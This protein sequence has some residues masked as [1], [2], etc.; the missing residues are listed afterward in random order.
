MIPGVFFFNTNVWLFAY[1]AEQGFISYWYGKVSCIPFV[2]KERSCL[3]LKIWFFS[4]P[5]FFLAFFHSTC[6]INTSKARNI[7]HCQTRNTVLLLRAYRLPT[8]DRT[9]SRF[10]APVELQKLKLSHVTNEAHTFFTGLINCSIQ[11][12]SI[13]F[14]RVE[15]EQKSEDGEICFKAW[16]QFLNF[17]MHSL[18]LFTCGCDFIHSINAQLGRRNTRQREICIN[19]LGNVKRVAVSFRCYR[20]EVS[21][22]DDSWF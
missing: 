21:K 7:T 19:R 2:E 12:N 13:Q 1:H 10:A 16:N 20:N 22:S 6:A 18:I 5:P 11:F 17:I 3:R 14:Y 8:S 9:A 15:K 4:F